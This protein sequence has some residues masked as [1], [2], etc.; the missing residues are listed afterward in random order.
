MATISCKIDRNQ[1][2]K[3]IRE[4]RAAN[5]RITLADTVCAGLKLVI[6]S[7]SCSWTYTYRKRGYRDGGQRFPQRSMKIGDPATMT[8]AE[9]R[10]AADQIKA[11]VRAGNDPAMK[12]R[13]EDARKRA[14]AARKAT[15]IEWLARYEVAHLKAGETK[16]QKDEARNIRFALAEMGLSES[17]PVEVT[18]KSLR[19]LIEQHSDRPATSRRRFSAM[20]RF[21]D[22]LVDEEA[23]EANAAKAVSKRFRPKPVPPRTNYFHPRE[24]RELWH[25]GGLNENYLR[26]LRFMITTPLRAMEGADLRWDQVHIEQAE[27][28]FLSSD[29]K[30][31]EPFIMPLTE[32]AASLVAQDGTSLNGRVFQLTSIEGGRMSAWSHFTKK[33]RTI[34]GVESFNLHDLRR[35]FSTLMAEHTNTSLDVIDGLLNHKQSATRGGVI[36]HYQHAKQI[37]KRREAMREWERLLE[38]WL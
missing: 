1:I 14:E 15:C 27:L 7:Q 5:R 6:N 16:H 21:L 32:L 25:S 13:E 9:A 4:Q 3:S 38:G 11:Q 29:T 19:S 33:V 8:P 12:K 17:Y 10:L 22:Y 35:T 30:N 31:S 34:S 26:Y 20:S 2:E 36:R 23:I 24:L 37:D 18:A 28:R